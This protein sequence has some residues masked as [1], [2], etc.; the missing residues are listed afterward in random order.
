VWAPVVG[1]RRIVLRLAVVGTPRGPA[2]M[3]DLPKKNQPK[4]LP[5]QSLTQRAW[6]PPYAL[7]LVAVVI[8]TLVRLAVSPWLNLP[9]P[10][11]TYFLAVMV[12]AW[13]GGLG[14]GLF[15]TVLSVTGA[16]YFFIPPPWSFALGPSEVFATLLYA[17]QGVGVTVALELRLQGERALAA[18]LA[19]RSKESAER[20]HLLDNERRAKEDAELA[21]RE[22]ELARRRT[23]DVLASITDGFLAFDREWCFTYVNAE[24]AR[25]LGRPAEALIG[26]NLWK[27]FP[28][29]EATSFGQLYLRAMREGTVLELEDYYPPFDA[30]YAVR[31]YPSASGLSLYFRDVSEQFR[32]RRERL[33][34]LERERQARQE[35]EAANRAKDDFLALLS[36]EL[37]TPLNPIIGWTQLLRRG[38]LVREQQERAL[39]VIERNARLQN[40]LI[41]DLLDVNR[42]ERGKFHCEM[43]SF[44][45]V[46]VLAA[47]LEAVR[48]LAEEAGVRLEAQIDHAPTLLLGDPVRLQQVFWNLLTNAVKFTPPGRRVRLD[49]VSLKTAVC[50]VVADEGAGIAPEFLPHLWERFRQAETGSTRKKGGLGLG[51]FIVRHVVELHGGTVRAESAGEGRGATFTVELPRATS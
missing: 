37:R 35:A 8:A 25:T 6:W 16:A 27:E 11:I 29:L 14:P 18:A 12:A 45:L 5:G 47:A 4:E 24:G 32:I 50:V 33:E 30:H 44:D 31:A 48:S 17:V 10:F 42:I 7:A 41:C 20:A 15:A 39:E 22:A 49:L 23:A 34:L 26:T 3:K 1:G 21:R 2:S 38:G 36:H 43:R 46:P 40:Q 13:Q 51:L 19:E 9:V 28:E